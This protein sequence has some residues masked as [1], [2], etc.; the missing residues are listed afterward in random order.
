VARNN[1]FL[2]EMSGAAAAM[3]DLT[4][5]FAETSTLAVPGLA[6][7]FAAAGALAQDTAPGVPQASA[8]T[9]GL[10]AGGYITSSHTNDLSIDFPYGPSPV[11]LDVSMTFASTHGGGDV[12]SAYAPEIASLSLHGLF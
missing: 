2:A 7:G 5:T 8:T 12:L 6:I 10:V 9:I 1:M 11:S 4:S 3:G